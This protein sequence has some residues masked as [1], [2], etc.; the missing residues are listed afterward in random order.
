[1]RKNISVH[2]P[3]YEFR[4]IDKLPLT[5]KRTRNSML[6]INPFDPG[7]FDTA[8]L[9]KLDFDYVGEN[10]QIA[11]N[12]TIIGLK[13]IAIGDNVRID[14][15]ATLAC[16]KG[17]LKIGSYIHISSSCYLGCSGGIELND[18]SGLSQGVRVYSSSDDYSGA[19]LTN[20]TIPEKFLN[21]KIKK[22]VIGR[23]VIIGSGSVILPGVTIGEG[24]SVGALSLVNKSLENWGIYLGVPAKKIKSRKD[25]LIDQEKL[26]LEERSS[27]LPRF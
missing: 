10:V 13:N 16:A 23:H 8:E 22:V 9:R 6:K 14:G 11:K 19:S 21:T 24:S 1:M 26:L 25:S 20:P 4:N 12:C 3:N 27:K 2:Y 5:T 15:G 7:Y 17:Y 18:F